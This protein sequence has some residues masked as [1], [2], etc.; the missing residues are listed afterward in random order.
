VP[1]HADVSLVDR[2]VA[3]VGTV[4]AFLLAGVVFLVIVLGLAVVMVV[5]R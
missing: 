1:K 4:L 5:T 2:V 3:L